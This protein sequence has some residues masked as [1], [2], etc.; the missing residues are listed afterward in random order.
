MN[1]R[2]IVTV[3]VEGAAMYVI[4]APSQEE[5]VAEARREFDMDGIE[6]SNYSMR[7]RTVTTQEAP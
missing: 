5:A 6:G 4:H 7:V 2:Y 3:H 1:N